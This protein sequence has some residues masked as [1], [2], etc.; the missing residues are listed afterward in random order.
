[1][2]PLPNINKVFSL[3]LQQERQLTGATTDMKVLL[4]TNEK[5][6]NW[7]QQEHG[8]WK[9]QNHNQNQ[10]FWKTRERGNAWC[11]QGRGRGRSNNQSK[12]CSYYHKTNHTVDEC[13]S[14]HGYCP[15]YKQ[16]NEQFN[17][18]Q[19][20]TCN[21][22]VKSDYL[23]SNN[24]EETRRSSFTTDQVKKL[25]QLLESSISHG[26]NK[27]QRYNSKTTTTKIPTKGKNSWI[28]STSATNHVTYLKNQFT[29]LY[30]I[31]P[32]NIKLPNGSLITAHYTGTI[33]ISKQF[34][35]YNV[36]Y[37]PEFSFK[38]IVVHKLIKDLN[39]K[40]IFPLE[41]CHIQDNISS[42]MIGQADLH[43]GLYY[44]HD[45]NIGFKNNFLLNIFINCNEHNIDLWHYRLGHP[46]SKTYICRIFPYVH[47][48]SR[49]TCATCHFPNNI[50]YLFSKVIHV[51]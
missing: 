28:L 13:Y 7:K 45:F 40:L 11:G 30:K 46:G 27:I 47:S 31:K 34:I 22:N 32:I 6:V 20:R 36:L 35:I 15:W 24:Q 44:L 38:K 10:I 42:K 2:D 29:V 3:V 16:N 9:P 1:M 51:L 18:N 41:K 12:Q 43:Q 37:V 14:K 23:Q 21:L 8:S 49:T 19:D 17:T 39:S 5:S 50:N 33:Q 26:I 4:N 25:L 48:I